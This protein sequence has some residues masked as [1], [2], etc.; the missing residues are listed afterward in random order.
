AL[1]ALAFRGLVLLEAGRPDKRAG[2]PDRTV[3]KGQGCPF[4]GSGNASAVQARTLDMTRGIDE[5]IVDGIAAHRAETCTNSGTD[6]PEDAADRS[7]HRLQN[8]C[9][10]ESDFPFGKDEN[11]SDTIAPLRHQR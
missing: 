1:A 2:N 3:D 7:T 6:R 11:S 4:F 9:G 10:H 5:R 8:N